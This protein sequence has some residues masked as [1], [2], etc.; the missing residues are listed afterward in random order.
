MTGNAR[1]TILDVTDD[2]SFARI[3]A[4]ADPGFDHRS[5]DYWEDAD[6]GSKAARLTWLQPS[7]PS[8]K[9][10]PPAA[11]TN[12]F[13]ADLAERPAVAF[14]PLGSSGQAVNPFLI[15]DDA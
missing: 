2:S 7:V 13:L 9:A 8:P 6:R 12:P 3:P 4:C 15:D 5:C 11:S 1:V 14:G 10:P